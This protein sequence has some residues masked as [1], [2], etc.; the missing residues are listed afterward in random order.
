M[1]LRKTYFSP[2]GGTKKIV[3][4][5]AE[6]LDRF[7]IASASIS[8]VASA[9]T[10]ASISDAAPAQTSASISDAALLNT[11]DLDFTLPESRSLHYSYSPEDLVIF[12]CPTYAGKLP[13][14]LLPFIQNNLT[15]N[16][17]SAIALVTFGNRSF[18]NSLAELAHTLKKN[19]FKVI[20]AAAFVTPHAFSHTLG[21]GRPDEEDL[22][23]I[24][25]FAMKL[26][27]KLQLSS[28]APLSAPINAPRPTSPLKIPGTWDAP[29]Y[30]PLG[31]DG[32]PT[33]FLKA[34]PA[35]NSN[36]NNC[37]LCAKLCP[38][39]AINPNN[40]AEVP[41]TCIKCHACVNHCPTAAKYFDD[42]AFLSHK[43]MLESTY[44]RRAESAYYL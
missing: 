18:D 34:K 41:G 37:G 43:Q 30:T 32:N 9:P 26:Q 8:D 39:A 11:S 4:I 21:A 28:G 36:C 22:A 33:V 29:Y 13:N 20:G 27:N 3:N 16:G 2:N 19:N 40:P 44:T 35:T 1:K 24:Q 31:I 38:M 17:A 5:V 42:P 7:G 10:S 14:K 25:E 15:G 12:A 6:A 23:L